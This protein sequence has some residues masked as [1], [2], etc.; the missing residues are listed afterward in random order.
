M[1]LL[2][3]EIL[4]VVWNTATAPRGRPSAAAAASPDSGS[5]LGVY[6]FPCFCT[7]TENVW[8]GSR[9]F[10]PNPF[11]PNPLRNSGTGT[12]LNSLP[13]A[14]A[15]A[16]IARR[17]LV[18]AAAAVRTLEEPPAAAATP[19]ATD[20]PELRPQGA[21]VLDAEPST[22]SPSSSISATTI[23]T[24]GSGSS[25]SKSAVSGSKWIIDENENLKSTP[26]MRAWTWVSIA[27]IAATLQQA[28][29]QVESVEDMVVFGGAV[30]LAYILSDLGT[31]I[32]HWGVDN[33]GD[34]NTPVFGRQIAAF[35]GHHQRP[36]TITQR[37]FANNLHQVFGPASYAA[38]ALLSLSPVMPLGWNA[39]SSSFLFLVC[40][41]QQ[42]HAWS[43][44]KK[45]ELPPAVVALQDSGLL[46]GRRMHGAHHKAPF[47]GNYCIVSGW[48]NPLLDSSGF[49]RALEK[50]IH[51]R[52]GVAPRC[53]EDPLEEWKELEQPSGLVP[54]S[55]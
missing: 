9:W 7:L 20:L 36:W 49:F 13:A 5:L 48:W 54:A 39:W 44:M 34:G 17:P 28:T 45:S 32:Y 2:V 6:G 55:E 53:W 25:S 14:A 18:I 37:E 33:Y 16:A 46:I 19:A 30:L 35:Q 31:G 27:M 42:F 12:E 21:T 52:T 47:E 43:H 23:S 51:D 3:C 10:I 50:L 15:A 8:L 11:G 24:T 41:S 40:M 1:F 29:K 4:G 22:S 38:A 26:E